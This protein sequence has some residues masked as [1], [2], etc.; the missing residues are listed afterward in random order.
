MQSIL[1]Q[2]FT[3]VA[4]IGFHPRQVGTMHLLNIF[5]VHS[6]PIRTLPAASPNVNEA[7]PATKP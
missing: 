5:R 7:L 2:E 6:I 3:E 4:I 1:S